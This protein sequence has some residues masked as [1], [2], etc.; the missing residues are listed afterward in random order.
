MNQNPVLSTSIILA[1]VLGITQAAPANDVIMP[2]QSQ[3]TLPFETD[4]LNLTVANN[5][6]VKCSPPLG[7][8]DMDLLREGV[9]NQNIMKAV[10]GQCDTTIIAKEYVKEK[11]NLEKFLLQFISNFNMLAKG[12]KSMDVSSSWESLLGKMNVM[13]GPLLIAPFYDP[14][15][16]KDDLDTYQKS[17]Y[18]VMGGSLDT[19]CAQTK[20]DQGD[21]VPFAVGFPY[22]SAYNGG[23][24]AVEP[25]KVLSTWWTMESRNIPTNV[26]YSMNKNMSPQCDIVQLS[27]EDTVTLTTSA[28]SSHSI[29]DSFKYSTEV[30][31]SAEVG[32]SM[33]GMSSKV[34]TEVKTGFSNTI[35]A[36]YDTSK[37]VTEQSTSK[38]SN[39]ETVRIPGYAISNVTQYVDQVEARLGYTNDT[40]F[41]LCQ[42]PPVHKHAERVYFGHQPPHYNSWSGQNFDS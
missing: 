6:N 42:Y 29:S 32:A 36:S 8:C 1:A 2:S 35:S 25:E 33:A 15:V 38:V 41:G 34:S 37:T 17:L 9:N 16:S 4:P 20:Y 30:K 19:P 10:G 11:E 13:W 5:N 31:A 14:D 21:G 22:L 39:Y 26:Q 40:L 27:Y 23:G 18:E 28:T 3:P 7:V 12:A 24:A